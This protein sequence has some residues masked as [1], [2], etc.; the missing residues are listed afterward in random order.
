MLSHTTLCYAALHC[1]ILQSSLFIL[2]VGPVTTPFSHPRNLT[3][4]TNKFDLDKIRLVFLLELESTFTFSFFSFFS[5]F[6]GSCFHVSRFSFLNRQSCPVHPQFQRNTPRRRGKTVLMQRVML[7]CRIQVLDLIEALQ[8]PDKHVAGLGQRELLADADARPAVEGEELPADFAGGPARRVE[9]VGIGAPEVGAAV[10]YVHA[11]VDLGA[12]WHEDGRG[13]RG[14][15]AKGQGGVAD[16][17]ARV[18]RD[19]RV[20]TQCLVEDVLEVG[21]G[22]ESGKGDVAWVMVGAKCVEN[23]VAEG[24]EDVRVAGEQEKGPAEETRGGVA[25]C[26]E[27]V[28]KLRAQFDRVTR[29][30]D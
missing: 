18:E 22:F 19:H 27:N 16:G 20:E 6:C 14:A 25:T 4:L 7:A 26:E 28:E 11:V 12:G 29:G 3:E 17:A 30:F 15:A 21:T 5:S 13:T 1:T 2:C 24:G 23:G 9:E 8:H 10:H